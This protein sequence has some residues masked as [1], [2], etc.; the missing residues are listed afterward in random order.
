MHPKLI[1]RDLIIAGL[2]VG[3]VTAALAADVGAS[4]HVVLSIVAAVLVGLCGHLL[5]EYGHLVASL[6]SRSQ[7]RFPTRLGAP[8]VFDFEVAVNSRRQFLIMST[9]GYLGSLLA[10]VLIATLLP[11]DTLVGQIALGLALLG[12]VASAVLE[13]PT[14]WRV[15][16]G[17]APPEAVLRVS[18][19]A[20]A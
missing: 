20:G 2:M 6:L 11:R 16:R 12:L 14:T 4:A 9:G 17:A 10:V 1:A 19:S 18:D 8:L 5:H 7:V 13:G 15:A 3:L